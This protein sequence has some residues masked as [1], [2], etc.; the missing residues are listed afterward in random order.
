MPDPTALDTQLA[1]EQI[2]KRRQYIRSNARARWTLIAVGMAL[3][4]GV[5][6][7]GIVPIAWSFIAAAATLFVAATAAMSRLAATTAYRAWHPIVHLAIGTAMI[8]TIIYGLGPTGHVLAAAYLI[9][10]I[11]AAVYLGRREAWAA[12]GLQ[13]VGFAVV[14]ALRAGPEAWTWGVFVQEALV[15]G[16]VCVAAIPL[17]SNMVA[18]LRR[19][20]AAL[21]R[22]EQGD[23][24]VRVTDPERD[25]IGYLALSVGH[26]AEGLAAIVRAVQSQAHDLA[27]MAQQLAASAQ[28]LQAAAQQ[29]AA[30]TQGLAQGTERQR[31]LI[32]YGRDEAAQ[33]E[34]VASGLHRSAQDTETHM[35]ELARQ[36]GRHGEDIARA[37][38]L[39]VTLVG[40]LDRV[41]LTAG[42][43]ERGAREVGKLVDGITRIASQT[44]LLALNAAIE[45]A[46]AG[47]HGLG[48]KVVASE[49]RKLAEQAGR[50]AEEVRVRTTTTQE[51]IAAV[52][53]AMGEGR[54]A[55]QGVGTASEAVRR[56]LDAIM[57]SLGSTREFA[58]AF[59]SATEAQSQRTR[60]IVRRME[61]AAEIAVHAADGAQQ[62][63]AATEQQ[64]S[65]LGELTTTS[66]HLSEAAARLAE[67]V[68]RFKVNGH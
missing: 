33:I 17:L 30:T 64:I 55:A 41:A 44:D 52:L 32:G 8:S 10:P 37:N 28:E 23:L 45:A 19:A 60:E 12:L 11:Q 16:F 49:V 50:A 24:T 22:L 39:L 6:L 46:R 48:F 59:A 9:A 26:T 42:T 54:E 20:R 38:E 15:L 62:T 67:T 66:Q 21:A 13:L 36:A 47:A 5:K 40:H 3:L 14:T 7:A 65:S 2:A 18:R 53:A 63:S 27:A 51:Q 61:Q 31:E 56:A 4:A 35:A 34:S 43:L 29:I 57:A 1:D 25:E 58:A 68:G